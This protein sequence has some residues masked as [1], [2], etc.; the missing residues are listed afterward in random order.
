MEKVKIVLDADVIIHFSKG[1]LLNVL[2]KIFSRIH[3]DYATPWFAILG[4]M[5]FALVVCFLILFSGQYMFIIIMA[6]A[7]ECFIY[8]VMALC[9]IRLRRKFPDRERSFKVPGGYPTAAAL[10]FTLMAIILIMLLAY[11]R[12]FGTE[13]LL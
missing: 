5:V 1:C 8:V 13:N 6:A 11:T 9:V 12:K 3:P 2:P 10:S 4:L 7:L